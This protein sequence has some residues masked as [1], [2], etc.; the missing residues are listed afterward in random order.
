MIRESIDYEN[1]FLI[2]TRKFKNLTVIKTE[3]LCALI[4]ARC[5]RK[6]CE[7]ICKNKVV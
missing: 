1:G 7:K 2:H 4:V 6:I 3:L 5:M